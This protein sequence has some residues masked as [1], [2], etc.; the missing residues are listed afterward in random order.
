MKFARRIYRSK[1]Y[2]LIMT[3]SLVIQGIMMSLHGPAMA[4]NAYSKSGATITAVLC[5]GAGQRQITLDQDGNIV[6]DADLP[7]AMVSCPLCL[8]ASNVVLAL[9]D[10][11][12]IVLA[13]I[14]KDVFEHPPVFSPTSDRRPDSLNCLD[15]PYKA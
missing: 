9:P 8:A 5:T 15:P 11:Q 7:K 13:P 14:T 6:E 10:I 4:M 1:T 12:S 3:L 2:A